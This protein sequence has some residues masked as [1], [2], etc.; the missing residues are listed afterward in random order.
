MATRLSRT[1]NPD[2]GLNW[3]GSRLVPVFIISFRMVINNLSK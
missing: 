2:S 3:N 1:C